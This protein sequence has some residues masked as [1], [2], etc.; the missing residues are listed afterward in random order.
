MGEFEQVT[1]EQF[2]DELT[3][4]PST[5]TFRK[6]YARF[7][8]ATG[9]GWNGPDFMIHRG[10]LRVKGNFQAP[11]YCMLILGDLIVDGL[12]DLQNPNEK[13]FDEGGLFIVLGDVISLSFSSEYGKCVFIDGD[14]Q[15]RDMI[16]NAFGDSSL[17]VT[18]LLTTKFFYGE[19]IWAEVGDGA[20]IEYGYGYCLPIGYSDA[21]RQAIRPR[22]GADAVLKALD[23]KGAAGPTCLKLRQ[24]LRSGGTIFS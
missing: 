5:D 24:K 3:R 7:R 6:Q 20:D 10:P 13:G 8:P 16:I 9:D 11:G 22:R 21:T 12:I 15:S 17:I 1:P 23:I 18:G 19:D 4:A 2:A 14:L